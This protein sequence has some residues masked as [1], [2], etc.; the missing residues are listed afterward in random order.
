MVILNIVMEFN[1]FEILWKFG[2]V[3]CQRKMLFFFF[4]NSQNFNVYFM[5]Y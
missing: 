2:S 3:V 5:T 1:D 4:T